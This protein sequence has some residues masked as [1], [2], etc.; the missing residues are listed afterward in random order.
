[1]STFFPVS[2][3]G[4]Q[5]VQALSSAYRD[6]VRVYDPSIALRSDPQVYET[7]MREPVI[8]QAFDRRTTLVAGITWG[9]ETEDDD[10]RA[11]SAAKVVEALL[12]KIRGF[13]EARKHMASAIPRGTSF[14]YIE[15]EKRWLRVGR[16][17]MMREWIVPRSLRPLDRR[18]LRA[19]SR[20]PRLEDGSHRI[21]VEWERWDT[22]NRRWKKVPEQDKAN[23]LRHAYDD[24]PE[25]LGHGRGLIDAVYFFWYFL[26]NIREE[27]L[28]GIEFWSRGF[29]ETAVDNLREGTAINQTIVDN[30]VEQIT[31][32]R[33]R[34]VFVHDAKDEVK[35]TQGGSEGTNI[36]LQ[37]IEEL[38]N[39]IRSLINHANL[40]V[41]AAKGGSYALGDTQA[42][43][44]QM[45]VQADRESL[46]ETLTDGLVQPVWDYNL[47][48]LAQLGLVDCDPGKFSILNQRLQDPVKAGQAFQIGQAIGLKIPTRHAYSELGIP[49]PDED[50]ECLTPP[51]PAGAGGPPGL[52]M[53]LDTLP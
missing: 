9:I 29:I 20:T 1:M 38:K 46:S 43:S 12:R 31:T 27:L 5:F 8:L 16:D 39:E 28:N 25:R 33:S 6:G 37:A 50:E 22:A 51:A 35:L 13:R 24:G 44:E 42:D 18:E 32:H 3:A 40:N 49:V 2:N 7:M 45:I 47:K 26:T 36:C 48:N 30:Y 11:K 53:G 52:P 19:I 41:S 17:K 4:Q 10:P 15:W 21:S 34:H 14:A 23:Y